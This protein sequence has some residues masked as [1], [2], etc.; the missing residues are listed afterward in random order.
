MGRRKTYSD[1]DRKRVVEERGYELL[2][3]VREKKEN[4]SFIYII[5][6]CKDGHIS[7]M[8]W[9]NFQQNKGCK[10]CANNVKFTLDEIKEYIEKFEY[11]L[12]GVEEK[13]IILQ[14]EKNHKPYKTEFRAF[15]NHNSRCPYCYEERRGEETKH[16]YEYVREY[17]EKFEYKLLSTKYKNENDK[18]LIQCPK[19]HIYKTNFRNFKHKDN[20]CPICKESKGERKIS[21]VLDKLNIKYEPQYKF[22]NCKHKQMLPFDF[23]LSKYNICI[24]YQGQQH[25]EKIEYFGGEKKF[26]IQKERDEIKRNYCK[27]NNIR[28]IEIPYWEYDNIEEILKRELEL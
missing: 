13:Y 23:Y 28:L 2:E 27:D 19:G 16:S 20:R 3:I 1:G 21:Y 7:K 24:E 8:K 11:K 12:L 4:R 25:Y 10:Y 15:K 14:C 18:L 17:I 5:I 26:N 9:D 6:K 22:K